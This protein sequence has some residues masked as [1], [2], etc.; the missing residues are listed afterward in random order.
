MGCGTWS[1]KSFASYSTSKRKVVDDNGYVISGQSFTQ[2]RIHSTLNPMNAVRMCCNTEEHPN[3]IPVILALD[4]TGSMGNACH[5]TASALSVIMSELFSK[6]KDVEFMVMG[7]GDFECDDAPLQVSQFESDVRI[8]EH[9]DNIYMEHG[10]GGNSYESYTA[11]WYYGLFRTRLDC[12][13][14]Q[15]RKGIIITMGDEPM[16]P[17]LRKRDVN[18][19]MSISDGESKAWNEESHLCESSVLYKMCS[20]KFDIYHIVVD[21]PSSSA[22]YHAE[23]INQTFGPLLG[24][25]LKTSNIQSLAKTIVDCIDNALKTSSTSVNVS[26]PVNNENVTPTS[27]T[28]EIG[29]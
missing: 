3:T 11:A 29:W 12:F 16:N 28:G 25:K 18:R 17:F 1:A 24:D 20:E 8:A 13:E 21:E 27:N 10:G 26:E 6:Y 4:V 22:A 7:I 23:K 19:V 9:L 5:E 14:K 15:N 2:R